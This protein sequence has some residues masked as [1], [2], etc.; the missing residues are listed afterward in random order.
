LLMLMGDGLCLI[1]Y[2]GVYAG[3]TCQF[4]WFASGCRKKR[5]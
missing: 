1:T 3:V 2:G 4:G 5:S